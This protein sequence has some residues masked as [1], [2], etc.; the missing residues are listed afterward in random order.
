MRNSKN[1][2]WD[3]PNKK[4]LIKTSSFSIVCD[5]NTEII[6]IPGNGY[7]HWQI[8]RPDC[9]KVTIP[10]NTARVLSKYVKHVHQDFEYDVHKIIWR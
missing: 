2:K 3:Y 10:A 4:V 1:F 7:K 9:F 5:E 6:T 8:Y